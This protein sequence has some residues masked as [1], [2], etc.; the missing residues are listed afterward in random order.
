MFDVRSQILTNGSSTS[1]AAVSVSGLVPPES[2]ALIIEME[3]SFNASSTNVHSSN[4]S[5][6][7]T[8][9]GGLIIGKVYSGYYYTGGVYQ[10]YWAENN[11]VDVPIHTTDFTKALWYYNYDSESR[12]NLFLL[13][14]SF[15]L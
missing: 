14:F 13:G 8:A 11:T 3:S 12:A 7:P 15:P 2:V 9:F 4:I 1:W 6:M 5:A 10:W